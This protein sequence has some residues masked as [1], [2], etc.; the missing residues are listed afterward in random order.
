[1]RRVRTTSHPGNDV[2]LKTATVA[3][4]RK[5]MNC[6]L[7]TRLP[8]G[9]QVRKLSSPRLDDVI[10]HSVQMAHFWISPQRMWI[11]VC[12]C[13]VATSKNGNASETDAHKNWRKENITKMMMKTR[14][15]AEIVITHVTQSTGGKCVPCSKMGR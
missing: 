3:H 13:V 15:M 9:H 8:F 6:Q 12:V 10:S 14:T 2:I 7:S 11:C 5:Q 1:M 4:R